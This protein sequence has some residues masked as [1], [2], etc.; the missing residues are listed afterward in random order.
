[1]RDLDGKWL[2]ALKELCRCRGAI[3]ISGSL[4]DVDQRSDLASDRNNRHEVV[5]R[6]RL[7]CAILYET[8]DKD[9]VRQHS[10]YDRTPIGE[11][12]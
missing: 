1:M 3:S 8:A 5:E 9:E 4:G 10:P 6:A 2:D 12:F 11:A 7:H